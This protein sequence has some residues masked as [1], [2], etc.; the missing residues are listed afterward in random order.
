MSH[1]NSPQDWARRFNEE[2]AVWA[3]FQRRRAVR[4]ALAAF[5]ENLRALAGLEEISAEQDW[6]DAEREVGCVVEAHGY[7]PGGRL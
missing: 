4:A 3:A 2:E 1:P 5:P 6:L 7:G